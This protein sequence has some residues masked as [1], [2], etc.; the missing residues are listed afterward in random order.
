MMT[1]LPVESE[2]V[3]IKFRPGSWRPRRPWTRPSRWRR[4]AA[5]K[6]DSNGGSGEAPFCGKFVSSSVWYFISTAHLSLSRASS[7]TLTR[8]CASIIVLFREAKEIMNLIVNN[9]FGFGNSLSFAKF[10]K[11]SGNMLKKH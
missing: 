7:T 4:R 3:H 8:A 2:M 11:T 6:W 1:P 10:N 5:L 9:S